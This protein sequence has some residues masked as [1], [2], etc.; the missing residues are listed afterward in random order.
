MSVV[1]AIIAAVVSL[2]LAVGIFNPILGSVLSTV[3]GCGLMREVANVLAEATGG[4]V[5]ICTGG[6]GQ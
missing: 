3:Q 2:A 4:A 5:D 1:V 6:A